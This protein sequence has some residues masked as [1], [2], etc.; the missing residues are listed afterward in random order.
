MALIRTL[1]EGGQ[2]LSAV[3]S[4]EHRARFFAVLVP[5]A[6]TPKA[7]GV[8]SVQSVVC[9]DW[10]AV[11]PIR[12]ERAHAPLQELVGL[13]LCRFPM[14]QDTSIFLEEHGS[15]GSE[16]EG[17]SVLRWP[18]MILTGLALEVNAFLQASLQTLIV[19]RYHLLVSAWTNQVR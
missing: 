16:K 14:N 9:G 17:I 3:A 13:Q 19:S 10:V 11:L 4:F 7:T 8:I 2:A 18:K 5:A 12:V 1:G 15:T 6:V